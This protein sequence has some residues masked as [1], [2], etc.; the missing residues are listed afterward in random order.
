MCLHSAR[1]SHGSYGLL[2]VYVSDPDKAG[3]VCDDL[4]DDLE[5]AVV[6]RENGYR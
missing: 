3:T 6:C 2:E 5:C 1:L 4:F